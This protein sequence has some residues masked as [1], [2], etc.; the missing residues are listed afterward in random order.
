[1]RPF[2]LTRRWDRDATM[3]VA[4]ASAAAVVSLL[5]AVAVSR[6]DAARVAVAVP[7][8]LALAAVAVSS[9]RR[10]VYGLLTWLVL[11]GVLRRLL[12]SFGYSGSVL[13]G[14]PLLLVGPA[15]LVLLFFVATTAGAFRE[16]TPLSRSVLAFTAVLALSALNPLQG[17]LSTGLGGLQLVVLPMLAFWVGRSLLDDRGTAIVIYLLG[18]LAVLAAIYGLVQTYNGFPSWDQSWIRES[19]Y[20]ALNVGGAVRAFGTSTSAS[21]YAGLLA[22]G[23]LSWRAAARRTPWVPIASVAIAVL[24]VA[25]WLESSRGAI[26]VAL[27]ALWLT[28]AAGRRMSFPR[29]LLMGV[30]LLLLLPTVVG[31][32]SRSESASPLRRTRV[33]VTSS[34]GGHQVEG[35]SHPF[36]K[37]STLG[38]HF[39]EVLNAITGIATNP[40]GRGVGATTIAATKFGNGSASAEADPGNAAIA[41]GA[42]G[43]ALY[44]LIA[45]YGVRASYRLARIRPSIPTIGALGIVVVT[46][47]QWLGGGQYVIILI[48]WL[49]LGWVDGAS[50]RESADG[51]VAGAPA[52]N[53]AGI[54]RA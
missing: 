12:T 32:L 22:I 47:L 14:D 20:T 18:S 6:P 3:T 29:A 31:H 36:G 19:G 8:A 35:L 34:L 10:A 7:I 4:A 2:A 50:T 49:M 41:A 13:G 1:M 5:L 40:L 45:F 44:L 30:L 16:Q 15:L 21:E 27:A 23:I 17:G 53:G 25:L 11:L 52:G 38:I 46:F 39:E 37:N 9:P 54:S 24:A 33:S 26:V 43:L 48:A 42:V 51:R 28:F